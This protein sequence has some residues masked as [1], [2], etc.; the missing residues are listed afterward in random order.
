MEGKSDKEDS[1]SMAMKGILGDNQGR[2]MFLL[3]F[4]GILL[5]LVISL[6]IVIQKLR[7]PAG[8][9]FVNLSSPI[10]VVWSMY[11]SSLRG[12]IDAYLNSFVPES[13][14]SIQDTLDSMGKETFREYLRNKAIGIMGIS[15][16]SSDRMS[17][18]ISNKDNLNTQVGTKIPQQFEEDMLSLPVEIIFKGRN[19]VQIFNLKR[20]GN[21]WKILNVSLPTL[22][23]QPIPYGQN[24]NE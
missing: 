19:E 3:L 6:L 20:I 2:V 18:N 12:D 15:I 14:S 24:V 7:S 16:Y 9:G 4:V 13:Q 17:L 23:P 10:E 1:T 5:V 11:E 8:K 22:T 21:A